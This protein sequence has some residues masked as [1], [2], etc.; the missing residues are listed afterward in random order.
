[1]IN[2]VDD[3]DMWQEIDIMLVISVSCIGIYCVWRFGV[4]PNFL[5]LKVSRNYGRGPRSA[6][7]YGAAQF[8]E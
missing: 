2:R 8:K 6:T 7:K 1:M 3:I 5:A 4:V